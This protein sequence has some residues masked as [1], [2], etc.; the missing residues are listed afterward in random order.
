MFTLRLSRQGTGVSPFC[1]HLMY[2]FFI[3]NLHVIS[4]QTLRVQYIIAA[5]KITKYCAKFPMNRTYFQRNRKLCVLTVTILYL[6]FFFFLLIRIRI[7][8]S[9]HARSEFSRLETFF[10]FHF[11]RMKKNLSNSTSVANAVHIR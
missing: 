3:T 2:S 5:T 10:F 9:E 6:F 1:L 8:N 11:N 4:I 7:T